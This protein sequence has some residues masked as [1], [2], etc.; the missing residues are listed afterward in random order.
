MEHSAF[1]RTALSKNVVHLR[2][3]GLQALLGVALAEVIGTSVDN[4]GSAD[5]RVRS[6]ESQVGV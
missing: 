2:V 4:N 3:T 5:D 1:E 6:D